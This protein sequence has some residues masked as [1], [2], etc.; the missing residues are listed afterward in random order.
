MKELNNKNI[1]KL[2]NTINNISK[3]FNLKANQ[4]V[5]KQ[6]KLGILFKIISTILMSITIASL[7]HA[8]LTFPIT[9]IIVIRN[10][11]AAL[12]I[13]LV[14]IFKKK[15]NLLF[16]TKN[17]FLIILRSVL[18]VCAM[19]CMYISFIF[20]KW[21]EATSI[22]FLTPIIV[23]ILSKIILKEKINQYRWYAIILGFIGVLVILS[24]RF[25]YESYTLDKL[26]IFGI[27]FGLIGTILVA[28][29]ML[30][31]RK[32]CQTEFTATIVIWFSILSS[33]ISFVFSIPFI[34]MLPSQRWVFSNNIFE[35][36]NLINIGLFGGIAQIILTESYR[37]ASA[38]IIATF[39]YL[40]IVWA[41]LIGWFLFNEAIVWQVCLGVIIIIYA[42]SIISYKEK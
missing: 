19:F 25:Y 41:V 39:G 10:L 23:A 27:V 14:F 37:Y 24:P 7:K 30:T 31:I 29:A 40:S 32:L 1:L 11:F 18:G 4:L 22:T 9:E 38:S 42:G 21:Q 12:P 26:T 20:L 5:S 35:I 15:L 3:T 17:Y 8:S 16:N 34:K 36:F 13:L 28:F 6:H 33:I 2:K